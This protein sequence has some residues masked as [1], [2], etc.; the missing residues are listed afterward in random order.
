MLWKLMKNSINLLPSLSSNLLY[1]NFFEINITILLPPCSL[2][3]AIPR[4][5]KKFQLRIFCRLLNAMGLE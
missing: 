1:P 5:E 3:L 2:S 4:N